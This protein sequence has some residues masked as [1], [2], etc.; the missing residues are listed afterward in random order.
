MPP[1]S[2]PTTRTGCISTSGSP[3]GFRVSVGA[4]VLR[5]RWG[6]TNGFTNPGNGNIA[7]GTPQQLDGLNVPFAPAYTAS[8][9]LDWKADFAGYGVGARTGASLSA[10]V[11]WD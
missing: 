1:F 8:T 11:Y 2:I 4:G 3:A 7:P 9:P 10:R 6:Q 5:A